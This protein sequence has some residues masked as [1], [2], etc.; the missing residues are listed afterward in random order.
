MWTQSTMIIANAELRRCVKVEV[1]V[2]GSPSLIDCTVSVDVLPL[3][4]TLPTILSFK[5]L[6][7]RAHKFSEEYIRMVNTIRELQTISS[8]ALVCM[9]IKQWNSTPEIAYN[10]SVL[11]FICV[12]KRLPSIT[13]ISFLSNCLCPSDFSCSVLVMITPGHECVN[14]LFLPIPDIIMSNVAYVF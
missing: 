13:L 9:V 6:I 8:W 7:T 4:W 10:Y 3:H 12:V 5:P 2:R 11:T 14:R 1:A